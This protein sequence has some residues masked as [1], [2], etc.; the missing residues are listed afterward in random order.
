MLYAAIDYTKVSGGKGLIL[1]VASQAR[2]RTGIT[3]G[4]RHRF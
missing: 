2:S 3:V 1:D 4:L